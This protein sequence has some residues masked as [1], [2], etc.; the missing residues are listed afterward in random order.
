MSQIRPMPPAASS[1]ADG[2]DRKTCPQVSAQAA[3][4][5]G[6]GSLCPPNATLLTLPPLCVDV[7]AVYNLDPFV[8]DTAQARHELSCL[9]L[10]GGVPCNLKRLAAFRRVS[11]ASGVDT[12]KS[13]LSG[14]DMLLV[15]WL[16]CGAV[17][18]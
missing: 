3:Q 9:L 15:S 2:T 11:K 16:N 1:C 14:H 13:S 18:V 5:H 8:D 6:G 4:H 10:K 12:A 7:R 17:S